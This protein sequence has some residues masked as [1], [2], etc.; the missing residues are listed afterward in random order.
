MFKV[1]YWQVF[2]M[3]AVVTEEAVTIEHHSGARGHLELSLW[4]HLG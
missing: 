2:A 4:F 1:T 3:P